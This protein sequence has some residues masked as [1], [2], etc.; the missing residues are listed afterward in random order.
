MVDKV[1]EYWPT[2]TSHKKLKDLEAEFIERLKKESIYARNEF[3]A[4]IFFNS[5]DATFRRNIVGYNL[6]LYISTQLIIERFHDIPHSY[7]FFITNDKGCVI[8]LFGEKAIL[9]KFQ[10]INFEQGTFLAIEQAGINAVSVATRLQ[11]PVIVWG[12]EHNFNLLTNYISLCN[13]I[14]KEDNMIGYLGLLAPID[15]EIDSSQLI[16]KIAHQIEHYLHSRHDEERKKYAEVLFDIYNLT[17]REKKIAYDFSLGLTS[18]TI[19]DIKNVTT[20]SVATTIKRVYSKMNIKSKDD[21]I[22]LIDRI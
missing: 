5:D 10:D 13:P 9:D 15:S 19:A 3:Q 20:D 22:M 11:Q 1:V 6:E 17:P 16:S 7:L 14:Q 21:L 18:E 2:K 4:E 8:T 12:S